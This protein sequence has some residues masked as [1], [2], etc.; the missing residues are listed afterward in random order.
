MAALIKQHGHSLDDESL[1]TLCEVKP[2][3]NS[4]PLSTKS[5]V[6]HSLPYH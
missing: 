2:V 1:Q 4:R 5:L 3:V 6:T